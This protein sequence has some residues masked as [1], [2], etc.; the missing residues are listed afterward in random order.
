VSGTKN[1]VPKNA[2]I[3]VDTKLRIGTE[4][5]KSILNGKSVIKKRCASRQERIIS[6]TETGY[7]PNIRS[8]KRPIEKR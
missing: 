4:F 3:I 8:G 6:G 1:I 7:W 5:V 2:N